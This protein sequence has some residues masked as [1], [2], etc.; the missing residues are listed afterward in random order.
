MLLDFQG[1]GDRLLNHRELRDESLNQTADRFWEIHSK[2][3]PDSGWNAFVH[4][5]FPRSQPSKKGAYHRFRQV[6]LAQRQDLQSTRPLRDVARVYELSPLILSPLAAPF[7]PPPIVAAYKDFT[8]SDFAMPKGC[9]YSLPRSRLKDS[10]TSFLR[11]LLEPGAKTEA[12]Q[13]I[14]EEIVIPM[15]GKVNVHLLD[16][17]V[18]SRELESKD[19]FHLQAEVR[20]TI[21]NC[22]TRI[23][24][25]LLI[26]FHD[27]ISRKFTGAVT[28]STMAHYIEPRGERISDPAGLMAF[29]KLLDKKHPRSLNTLAQKAKEQG[30]NVLSRNTIRNLRLGEPTKNFTASD[31]E[32]LARLYDVSP[33]ML[34]PFLYPRAAN[35]MAARKEDTEAVSQVSAE[36][37]CVYQIPRQRLASTNTSINYLTIGPQTSSEEH[38]HPGTEIV[39][40]LK[41][42]VSLKTDRDK[43]LTPLDT[44]SYGQ[45]DGSYRHQILNRG[46]RV[47]EVLI[48]RNYGSLE[49]RGPLIH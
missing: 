29:L 18:I 5:L 49:S 38:K 28:P 13:F 44:Q 33:L 17:G 34:Y 43:S 35:F 48:I 23:A 39:V 27:T 31:V 9:C 14:G 16:N 46:K 47:A 24:E 1:L 12:H 41:G 25:V 4:W 30:A 11:I 2:E 45:L 37:E 20:H 22:S 21:T 3:T 19:Y 6:E 15:R 10:N 42:R 8:E 40:P 7:V 26:R 36:D 32:D